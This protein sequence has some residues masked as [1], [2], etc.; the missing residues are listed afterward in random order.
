LLLPGGWTFPGKPFS[1]QP[2]SLFTTTR[3][4][5]EAVL[6]WLN[7]RWWSSLCITSFAV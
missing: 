5:V 7:E 4:G 1:L 2:L 6:G 3:D